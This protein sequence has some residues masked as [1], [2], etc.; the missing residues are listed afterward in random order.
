M[1]NGNIMQYTKLNPDANRL[2]LVCVFIDLKDIP[3][4]L[5]TTVGTNM[6]GSRVPSRAGHFARRYRSGRQNWEMNEPTR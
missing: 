4:T 5:P 1:P 3:L 6:Q 2:M